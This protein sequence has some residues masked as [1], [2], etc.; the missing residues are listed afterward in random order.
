MLFKLDGLD[1]LE[2]SEQSRPDPVDWSTNESRSL[3]GNGGSV[4]G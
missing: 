1:N 3:M 2:G 4:A